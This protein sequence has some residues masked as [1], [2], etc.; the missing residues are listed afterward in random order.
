MFRLVAAILLVV[1]MGGYG[2]CLANDV[3]NT[4]GYLE[5][6][7]KM[8]DK[9]ANYVAY[10]QDT[11]GR[12]IYKTMEQSNGLVKEFL[13]HVDFA[14]K[15]AEGKSLEEAWIES[16][17]IWEGVLMK[18]E[19]EKLKHIFTETGFIERK[20][21]VNA[22]QGYMKHLEEILVDL[23]QKKDGRIKVYSVSGIMC[24]LFFSILLW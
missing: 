16:C 20:M 6:L 24:G 2:I 11:I 13:Q 1:G 8:T 17:I 19:E 18:E 21:Q 7:Y 15:A 9:L 4:I 3:K 12:A 10:E 23:K 5:E 14:S 22:L